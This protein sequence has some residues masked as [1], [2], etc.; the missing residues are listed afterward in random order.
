MPIA[1]GI[2]AAKGA[3]EVG[4]I[5]LDMLRRPDIDI[6]G[7]QGQLLELQ[8]LILSAQGALG[9][10]G[11]ENRRLKQELEDARR[12][13]D[14]GSEFKFEEGLYWRGQFPYCPV[15]WDVDRKPTRLGGPTYHMGSEVWQCPFH[16]VRHLASK[17]H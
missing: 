11:D 3:F 12:M 13:V 16:K 4:K 7:V 9:E 15:C 5:A 8:G 6:A 14:F 17:R 2:A 10:A 1:E